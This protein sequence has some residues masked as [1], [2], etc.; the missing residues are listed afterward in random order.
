ME[1]GLAPVSISTTS[2]RRHGL[3]TQL[4]ALILAVR[5]DLVLALSVSMFVA[6]GIYRG[7]AAHDRA[8]KDLAG[9]KLDVEVPGIGRRDEIGEMAD[10]VEVFK[11]NAATRQD[12]RLSKRRGTRAVARR[13]PT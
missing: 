5:A 10:A 11:S 8:M 2:M 13:N 12:W 7:A 4:I 9:G 1:L 6:R 3:S